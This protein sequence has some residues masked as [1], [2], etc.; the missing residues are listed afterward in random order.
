LATAQVVLT[1]TPQE[2]TEYPFVSTTVE[3]L[4]EQI[5]FY[6]MNRDVL[7]EKSQEGRKWAEENWNPVDHVKEY[8]TAYQN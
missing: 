3:T 7:E 8:M 1:S 4:R 2:S 5:E 6:M